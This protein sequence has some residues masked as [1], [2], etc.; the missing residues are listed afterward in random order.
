MIMNNEIEERFSVILP[1]T[2]VFG[3]IAYASSAI[4]MDSRSRK[5][6]QKPHV[7]TIVRYTYFCTTNSKYGRSSAAKKDAL[8]VRRMIEP[9]AYWTDEE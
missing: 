7:F 8:S 2:P 3:S 4:L 5:R 1:S 6:P 9:E